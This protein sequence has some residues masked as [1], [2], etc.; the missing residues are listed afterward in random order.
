M[1]DGETTHFS[2]TF[3]NFRFVFR[4]LELLQIAEGGVC[5]TCCLAS[6]QDFAHL[7][8]IK[9]EHRVLRELEALV[10]LVAGEFGDA[11]KDA[12]YHV[13]GAVNS[14]VERVERLVETHGVAER[15]GILHH[16]GVVVAGCRVHE[17]QG[18]LLVVEAAA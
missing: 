17:V 4:W 15:G 11:A 5:G 10:D 1:T 16:E 12:V 7:S 2:H 9:T 3:G 18:D 8:R 14:R 13:V 6:G